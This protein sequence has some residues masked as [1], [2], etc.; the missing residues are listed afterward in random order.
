[1][2]L[3]LLASLVLFSVSLQACATGARSEAMRPQTP[4]A[5]AKRHAAN[6]RVA[7][8]GGKETNP[9]WKSEISSDA[10]GEALFEAM[11]QSAI[12]SDVRSG[13][14]SDFLLEVVLLDVDQPLIGASMT[15]TLTARWSLVSGKTNQTV[16]KSDIVKAYTAGAFDAFAGVTRLRLAN[17]G[18]AR[19]NIRAG[20]EEISRLT[21]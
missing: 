16:W 18:A 6:V 14:P 11:K 1:M 7:V 10:F 13:V 4:A 12:F 5:I 3:A 8:S 15:V 20:L 21:L 2:K 17:E 19:E 9:L